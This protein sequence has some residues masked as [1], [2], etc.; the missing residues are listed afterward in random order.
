MRTYGPGDPLVFSHIPKTAGTSLRALL[1]EALQP[2]VFVGGLD[3]SLFGGYYDLESIR[4]AARASIIA[5]PEDLPADVTLIAAH[6]APG[7]TMVRFPA[8]DHVTFL[9]TPEVRLLSQWIHSRSL[10]EFDLRWWGPAAE[11]FRVARLPLRAYL[12][13]GPTAPLTDNT[14]TRFLTWPDPRLPD[15]DYIAEADDD[16]LYAAAI[17]RLESF[18]HVDLVENPSFMSDFG[19]WLGRDLPD[20]RLNERTAMPAR[21]RPDLDTEMAAGTGEL[22]HHRSRIDRRVWQHVAAQVLPEADPREVMDAAL[23]RSVDRYR[24]L[25]SGPPVR[26]RPVR[27]AAELAYE[28]GY[29]VDPRRLARR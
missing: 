6:I 17:D 13:H 15:S 27:R 24:T 14:I 25:L 1:Q 26:S 8:A 4:G 23:R 2:T 21:R 11:A 12:E 19:G 9:R 29:R 22:L 3:R 10:S 20:T 16:A 18:A 5:A 28:V 7:T